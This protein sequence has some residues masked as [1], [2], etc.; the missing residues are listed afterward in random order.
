[1]KKLLLPFT[2][3]SALFFTACSS[4][5]EEP[6]RDMIMLNDAMHQNSMNSD[7]AA[8]SAIEPE[9]TA[10]PAPVAAPAPR[11]Y[12]EHVAHRTTIVR[13]KATPVYD[14]RQTTQPP[15]VVNTPAPAPTPV[16]TSTAGTST[17][18]DAAG[19]T[20]DEKA[21]AK[22]GGLSK[23]AQGAIIGGVGGAV[24][25]A[26][27]GKSG[28]GAIIGGVIGAAG[29]YILGRQKDKKEASSGGN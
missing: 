16:E 26:V 7:T 28:K 11:Q 17:A 8:T 9:E 6:T 24:G 4:K 19:T 14:N 5:T 29:G 15:V 20:E 3:V 13:P 21:T 1:M 2:I 23:A 18:G 10:P 25:G 27:I 12:R 22:K